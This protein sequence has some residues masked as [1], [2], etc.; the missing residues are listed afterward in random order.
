MSSTSFGSWRHIGGY[1]RAARPLTN[2]QDWRRR[3]KKD[4]SEAWKATEAQ[5]SCKA[6][7]VK[8]SR[9]C[10]FCRMNFTKTP[11]LHAQKCLPLLQL[12]FLAQRGG[13]RGPPGGR[14]AV[15]HLVPDGSVVGGGSAIQVSQ[16]RG[17]S[18]GRTGKRTWEP[19][20]APTWG[21]RS[22]CRGY[23]RVLCHVSHH[24]TAHAAALATCVRSWTTQYCGL[25]GAI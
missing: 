19:R 4:H 20:T 16:K 22:L 2:Q 25:S 3:V 5:I 12:A 14:E 18:Q 10:R 21:R 11:Q 7:S 15:G 17:T 13:N 1:V 6:S 9:P 23:L 8:L 24:W